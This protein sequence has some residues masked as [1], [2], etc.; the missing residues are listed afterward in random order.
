MKLCVIWITIFSLILVGQA[1]G[2][3]ITV[4]DVYSRLQSEIQDYYSDEGYNYTQGDFSGKDYVIYERN[5]SN[6]NYNGD[7]KTLKIIGYFN[8]LMLGKLEHEARRF[9]N[10]F[11]EISIKIT[12]YADPMEYLEVFPILLMTKSYGD[13]LELTNSGWR[14]E[15][16]ATFYEDLMPYVNREKSLNDDTYYMNAIMADKVDDHLYS[17]CLHIVPNGLFVLRKNVAPELVDKFEQLE[18]LSYNDLLIM[19]LETAEKARS[20]GEKWETKF[21]TGFNPMAFLIWNLDSLIDFNNKRA[22]FTDPDFM[23]LMERVKNE[24]YY[25]NEL[26]FSENGIERNRVEMRLIMNPTEALENHKSVFVKS[27]YVSEYAIG[28]LFKGS[29]YTEPR[30]IPDSNGNHHMSVNNRLAISKNSKLKE[31]AWNFMMYLISEQPLPQKNN[32]G[33]KWKDSAEDWLDFQKRVVGMIPVNKINLNRL[34]ALNF[35]ISKMTYEKEYSQYPLEGSFEEQYKII[36]SRTKD[37][38]SKVNK[39]IIQSYDFFD[40]YKRGI[41]WDDMYLYL[42]DK[43]TIEQTMINI[44]NK[45]NIWLNE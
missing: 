11:P 40:Y 35:P 3:R 7:K 42:T 2:V 12:V 24:V 34:I 37:M 4:D 39:T 44:E 10:D 45:V 1:C 27:L 6:P 23:K 9:V 29:Y 41:F 14:K 26:V 36:T 15:T 43:Q 8:S 5:Y 38:C 28:Y 25:G 33:D 13:L 20:K 31:E 16:N 22:N 21:Y 32:L 19:Y 18:D 17:L 30:L